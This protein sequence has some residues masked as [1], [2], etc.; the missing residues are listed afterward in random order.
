MYTK[1]PGG[2]CNTPGPARI[3]RDSDMFAPSTEFHLPVIPYSPIDALNRRAAAMGSPRYAQMTHYADYNGHH[4][5]LS[6]NDYRKYYVAEYMWAGRVVIARG[7]FASCLR[8]TIIMYERGALGASAGVAPREDDTAA[9]ELCEATPK[10]VR[11]SLWEKDPAG[12]G[13]R[14]RNGDWWT[15]RHE[16]AAASA[17]DMANPRASTLIFDWDLMQAANDRAEYEIALL[18]KYGRTYGWS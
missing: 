10:L 18:A 4:V 7:A 11:G 1:R 16:A 17:R 9:I 14:L 3:E 5:S 13:N 2:A 8:E 12:F 15:W 6:W